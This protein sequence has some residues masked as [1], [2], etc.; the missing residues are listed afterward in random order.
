MQP[1]HFKHR[2]LSGLASQTRAIKLRPGLIFKDT[3]GKGHGKLLGSCG[4]GNIDGRRGGERRGKERWLPERGGGAGKGARPGAPRDHL[5]EKRS[6]ERPCASPA[7]AH[8]RLNVREAGQERSQLPGLSCA[9]GVQ[10]EAAMLLSSRSRSKT[11]LAGP[12]NDT[13]FLRPLSIH[14]SS[15][16][17]SWRLGRGVPAW[18][19]HALGLEGQLRASQEHRDQRRTWGWGQV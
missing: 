9:E 4:V 10:R 15:R 2:R 1:R 5:E 19:R 7:P 8:A 6:W 17:G 3:I 11:G 13:A 12:G 18:P 16:S 14:P